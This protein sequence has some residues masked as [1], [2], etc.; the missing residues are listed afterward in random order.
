MQINIIKNSLSFL[1]IVLF[2]ASCSDKEKEMQ[3]E[4]QV[5]ALKSQVT[6]LEGQ[7]TEL[8][9]QLDE[10]EN[11]AEKIHAKMKLSFEEKDFSA[12]KSY[13]QQMEEKHADS[14]LFAEVK[15]IHD[16]VVQKEKEETERINNA[17][18][19]QE[20]ERKQKIEREKQEK[21]KALNKLKKKHDDISGVTL[22]RQ[23]Y[24]T[25]YTNSNKTSIY[26][27]EI[28]AGRALRL[29]MSYKGDSWIFFERAYLSYDGNTKEITFDKYRDKKTENDGGVVWEWIDVDIKGDVISFLREFAKSPNAKMRLSGKYT[30]TRNLSSNE[31]KG[32]LAVL[33]GYDVLEKGIK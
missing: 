26:I 15:N 23:P 8:K 9:N 30:K 12:C 18:K 28:G 33:D 29:M 5:S 21:L 10:C 32:I 4:T 27:G 3:L 19:K 11:G 17:Y 25:H 22:Y 14:E 13:Y 31:R 20:K 1:V 2:L 16:K 7:A 6:E 24:F